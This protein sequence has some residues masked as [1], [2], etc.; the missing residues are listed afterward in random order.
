MWVGHKS[1]LFQEIRT[2]VE[3]NSTV[4]YWFPCIRDCQLTNL[5]TQND[6]GWLGLVQIQTPA[7]CMSAIYTVLSRRRGHV[8]ADVPKPG[9]PAYVVKVSHGTMQDFTLFCSSKK[10]RSP[11]LLAIVCAASWYDYIIQFC[12]VAEYHVLLSHWG[13]TDH[14]AT[15]SPCDMLYQNNC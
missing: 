3:P 15:P 6:P 5:W 7:D 10:V 4:W 14:L 13:K 11:Q 2:C 1:I 12:V 9:T 8:T